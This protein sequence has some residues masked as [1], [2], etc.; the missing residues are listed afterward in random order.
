MICGAEHKSGT[1]KGVSDLI[2]RFI[3][4]VYLPWKDYTKHFI[5]PLHAIAGDFEYKRSMSR[6]ICGAEHECGTRNGIYGQGFKF[7]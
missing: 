6:V 4:L 5:P 1:K 7:K 3:M 2:F